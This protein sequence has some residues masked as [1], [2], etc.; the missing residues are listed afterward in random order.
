MPLT[1]ALSHLVRCQETDIA[2]MVLESVAHRGLL[3]RAALDGLL[4]SL[5]LKTRR[6]LG[7]IDG[8]AMSGPESRVRR[9]LERLGVTVVPQ[10]H[11]PGVGY[12]DIR[13]GE[14]LIIECDS[15]THHGSREAQNEDRRR[16]RALVL[17]GYRVVRLSFEDVV[18]HWERTQSFLRDLVASRLHRASPGRRG[19]LLC[20]PREGALRGQRGPRRVDPAQR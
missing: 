6:A 14:C 19:L 4:S 2:V 7:S 12:T 8:R 16:D 15:W 18:V 3:E 1:I 20:P 9:F 11:V 10:W 5:P 13:V 17:L